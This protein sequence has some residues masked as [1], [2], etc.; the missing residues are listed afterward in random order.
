MKVQGNFKPKKFIERIVEVEESIY[1]PLF[2]LENIKSMSL[3]W[4][5]K[6]ENKEQFIRVNDESKSLLIP[7]KN[8][9]FLRRFSSKD[10]KCR[11]IAAPDI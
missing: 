8:Y 4:P 2:W 7:N 9:I 11:L 3:I 5:I 1:A 10:D 6:K